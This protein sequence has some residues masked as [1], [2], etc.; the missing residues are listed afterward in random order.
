MTRTISKSLLKS[1]LSP[2]KLPGSLSI[3]STLAS[4]LRAN[5]DDDDDGLSVDDVLVVGFIVVASDVVV[6]VVIGSD[7]VVDVINSVVISSWT[8]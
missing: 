7:W 1:G 3:K 4:S 5:S 6:I 8:K 2:T